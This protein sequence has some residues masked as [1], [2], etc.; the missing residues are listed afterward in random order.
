MPGA[1]KSSS[2]AAIAADYRRIDPDEIKNIL[3]ARL[4]LEGLLLDIRHKHVLAD[5]NPICPGELAG[6]VHEAS[7]TAADLVRAASLQ[8][9]ENFAMEGTLSWTPLTQTH[10]D[11]LASN[12][13]EQLTILDVEVPLSVAVEQSKQRWWEGRHSSQTTD[14]TWL[15][16][17]FIA[18][19]I[20][21]Q[22]YSGPR[23][24]ST[25]A[26]NARKLY[27]NANRAG[28]DT[29]LLIVSR[30]A[31]G[32]EYAARLSCDGQVHPW[33][34][35]PLGAVCTHCGAILKQPQ[36]ILKG[37]SRSRS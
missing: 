10:V 22:L 29:D 7:T 11:E 32:T 25:C 2:L 19:T 30:T 14:G 34:D 20:L 35:V 3:L 24:A 31:N 8:I 12:D 36:A 37:T 26:G 33:R 6:W 5:G 23:S 13:Y 1:G 4:H 17:R 27:R 18:E 9:G 28:I 21:A 16:G 15:G